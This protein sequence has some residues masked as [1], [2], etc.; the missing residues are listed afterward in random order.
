MSQDSTR[1]RMGT[2]LITGAS[3]GI[4]LEFALEFARH[5]YDLVLVARN[6]SML[7]DLAARCRKEYAVPVEVCAKDLS[8]RSAADELFAHLQSK[9]ISIDALVNDAGFAIQ[10]PLAENNLQNLL[11]LLQVNIVALTHLTR[12]FLPEMVRRGHGRILNMSSIGA[13]I[14]GP[15]MAAYFASKA[16]V[17]SLSEGL[18]YELQGSGVTVTALCAGPTRTRF[19]HRARLIDAKAFRGTLMEP[20]PLAQQ[21]FS[22]MMKGK[23][24]LILPLKYRLQMIPTPLLPRRLLAYF[25]R[26]YHE[27]AESRHEANWANAPDSPQ[28]SHAID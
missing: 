24:V 9:N 2:A 23:Q 21:G 14:P 18:S 10:G 28:T 15:L 7:E 12:L 19:A 25:A 6:Q 22:A 8:N 1:P 20:A 5:G 26:Q 4:G 27:T 13:F 17:L 16:F 11:D 3:S